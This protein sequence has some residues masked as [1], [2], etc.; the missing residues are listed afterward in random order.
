[1]NEKTVNNSGVVV[2]V[3]D[4]KQRDRDTIDNKVAILLW[5]YEVNKSYIKE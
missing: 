4:E 5:T 1:M 3:T 2:G